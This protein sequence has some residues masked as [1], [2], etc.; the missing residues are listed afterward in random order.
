[1][2]KIR[3][4]REPDFTLYLYNTEKKLN[5]FSPKRDTRHQFADV[6]VI[7]E[8]YNTTTTS[9]D[10][11]TDTPTDTINTT[12][13]DEHTDTPADTTTTSPDEQTD[14]PAE[15][16]TTTSPDV[17]T[18]T[19]A[20]ATATTTSPDEHTDNSACATATTTSPDVQTDTSAGATATTTSPDE[21][22]DNSAGIATSPDVSTDTSTGTTSHTSSPDL[23]TVYTSDVATTHNASCCNCSSIIW[24]NTTIQDILES[25]NSSAI[26]ELRKI[27]N[28]LK[29]QLV[30]KKTDLTSYRLK[31]VSAA[32]TRTSAAGIGWLG[33]VIIVGIVL[34]IVF[35]D[36]TTLFIQK[37]KPNMVSDIS[38]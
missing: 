38:C 26:E 3:R 27:L 35:L 8:S 12:S 28:K 17:Q 4:K 21:H 6:L 30:V 25:E 14:T 2:N 5:W 24:G 29:A 31:K 19:S 16:T 18:D 13:P 1:M 20:G 11:Q 33:V 7:Q 22:T 34:V 15:T 10:E 9:P 32:D 23:S 36:I 37:K